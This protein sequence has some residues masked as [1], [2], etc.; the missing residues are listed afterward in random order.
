MAIIY[1]HIGLPK[2]GTTAI[3]HFLRNNNDVLK[4]HG[5]CYPDFG[6]TYSE[7]SPYRNGHFVCQY[8]KGKNIPIYESVLP[9]LE[10]LG[11]AFD[12]IILSDE[13]IWRRGENQ[14]ELWKKLRDDFKKRNLRLCIIVYLRRQDRFLL[15]YYRQRVKGRH[16]D[17]SFR[18]YLCES[19]EIY[20]LD[21]YSYMNMLS[22]ILGRE[23][24][25]I[26]VYEKE[27]FHGNLKTLHSDFL[28]IFGLSPEDGFTV[29]Q[30]ELNKSLDDPHFELRRLLNSVSPEITTD[31][32]LIQSFSENAK[33]SLHDDSVKTS[34]FPPGEQS[35]YLERFAETNSRLAREYLGRDNGILFYDDSDQELPLYKVDT[36]A[37]LQETIRFYARAFRTL[38]LELNQIKEKRTLFPR[39]KKIIRRIGHQDT[40][41]VS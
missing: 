16:T 34:F 26:R 15:S 31:P 13:A 37:L 1:L 35:A 21:Y 6:L 2:T 29:Q 17:L 11:K 27:Q 24:L 5:I 8:F 12:K 32:L 36:E 3:Q 41:P 7:I 14:P 20:P 39:L 40:R 22:D 23:N 4:E 19:E 9:Q 33:N 30:E 18:D 25:F 10:E 38:E 28:D